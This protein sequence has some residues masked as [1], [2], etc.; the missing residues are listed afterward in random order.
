MKATAHELEFISQIK[1]DGS[2]T[3]KVPESYLKAL[4]EN[5][6]MRDENYKIH[7]LSVNN[8]TFLALGFNSFIVKLKK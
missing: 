6:L 1:R 2:G 5:P 8:Q 4:K 7:C 3:M